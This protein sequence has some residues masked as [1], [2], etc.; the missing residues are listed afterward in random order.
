[1]KM[2]FLVL[3]ARCFND[4]VD[5]QHH[6]FTKLAVVMDF[7][8]SNKNAVGQNAVELNWG[9]H[10]NFATIKDLSYPC[11]FELDVNPTIKGLE[12]VGAKPIPASSKVAAVG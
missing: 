4:T 7:P 8:D 2:P 11:Q 5:G 3:G 12:L 6:D 9:D 10:K 1:M